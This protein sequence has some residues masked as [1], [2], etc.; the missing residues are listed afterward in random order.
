MPC[1][2]TAPWDC[3]QQ[4]RFVAASAYLAKRP[5]RLG[6]VVRDRT[7]GAVWRAGTTGEATWTA[8]TIKVAIAADLLERHRSGAIALDG[9]DRANLST[10][11]V[12]SSNDAAH[13]LWTRYDGP[14]MLA[15]FRDRYGM[16]GLSVVPGHD[17]YW[18]NLRCTAEDLSALMSYVLDSLAGEDRAYLVGRLRSVAGNQRW[19][20]WAAGAAQRPGNKAGW[21]Q[22]PDPEGTHWVT[23]TVGFAGPGER[24]VVAVTYRLLPTGSLGGG[25]QVVSDVVA[26]VFGTPVPAKVSAP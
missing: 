17:A 18:R 14:G 20:V 23:H 10:A 2:P 21:A 12:D 16:K 24:Y 22:K 9:T 3:A 11:L 26:H 5:G 19:G 1:D 7:T 6:V 13:A 25:V 8:S 4:R 15:R